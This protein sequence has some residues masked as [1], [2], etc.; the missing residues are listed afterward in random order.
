MLDLVYLKK[1]CEIKSKVSGRLVMNL[2]APAEELN[3]NSKE[4][5]TNLLHSEF[6]NYNSFGFNLE[7]PC[8]VSMIALELSLSEPNHLHLSDISLLQ[9]GEWVDIRTIEGLR[10]EQ[11]SV[12]SSGALCFSGTEWIS[13][14]HSTFFSTKFQKVPLVRFLLPGKV[15]IQGISLGNRTDGLWERAR[16]LKVIIHNSDGKTITLWDGQNIVFRIDR[17]VRAIA[18][19]HAKLS[20][21]ETV[22]ESYL[23]DGEDIR[24]LLLSAS[25]E[26]AISPLS[27]ATQ[28]NMHLALDRFFE[29]YLKEIE[30]N[31]ILQID[32]NPLF[33]L[34]SLIGI[35][36]SEESIFSSILFLLINREN[37]KAFNFL[38]RIARS[39]KNI[40]MA[41]LGMFTRKIGNLY[42]GHP[43]ILTA[44]TFQ[45]PLNSYDID[46][47]SLIRAVLDVL[48]KI[49][50]T[51]SMI[52]YG[53]LLGA[54]REDDF[55]AH[56]DD[57]DVLLIIKKS[58]AL[59]RNIIQHSVNILKE[60]GFVVDLSYPYDPGALPILQIKDYR[61]PVHVDVFIGI[62]DGPQI[63]MPM[64]RVKNEL[65]DESLL[66][67]VRYLESGKF[68]G[69]PVTSNPEGFLEK[70]YG[71]GWRIPDPMF[72]LNES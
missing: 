7:L 58:N 36:H 4:V 18:D 53:T 72:R 26:L 62:H 68:F 42:L 24:E 54:I 46:L 52:C 45:R 40:D 9:N 33:K 71:K 32:C 27:D 61:Y 64:N 12:E 16:T 56:D 29:F 39:N 66:L 70:R 69:L 41:R 30:N 28:K 14:S 1:I 48:G 13:R 60:N 21:I 31:S 15:S 34:G 59:F 25:S 20:N 67:P 57:I 47:V 5:R 3:G 22:S 55:I 38:Q 50:N 35:R 37:N 17:L 49:P 6:G 11:S 63:L 8:N 65:V 23:N 51:S 43:L 2:L 19:F 10:A 44:H